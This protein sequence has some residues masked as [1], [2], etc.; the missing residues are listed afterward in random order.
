MYACIPLYAKIFPLNERYC[1]AKLE[2]MVR[3]DGSSYR[4]IFDRV[5]DRGDM[6][7]TF[8]LLIFMEVYP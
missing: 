4:A 1:D 8:N 6:D 3:E 2:E 5:G 7:N